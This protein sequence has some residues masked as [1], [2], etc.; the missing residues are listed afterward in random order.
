MTCPVCNNNN[1][2]DNFIEIKLDYNYSTKSGNILKASCC[3]E[4]GFIYQNPILE[5]MQDVSH[6]ENFS[7]YDQEETKG[8]RLAKE[9][10]LNWIERIITDNGELINHNKNSFMYF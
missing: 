8:H 9:D 6:Y 10:Q 7:K 3:Y 1:T 4:C 5:T 2:L